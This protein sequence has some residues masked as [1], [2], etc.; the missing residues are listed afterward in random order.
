MANAHDSAETAFDDHSFDA[1]AL[2][3]AGSWG[4]G[5]A[6]A[7]FLAVM[8]GMSDTG[9]PRVMAALS[10]VTG[11]ADTPAVKTVAAA[12]PAP[13][14]VTPA[15]APQPAAETRRL[16]EQVQLL[17]ADRDRLAQRIGTLERNLE[18]V[19]GSIRQQE[20]SAKAASTTPPPTI[21]AAMSM[22]AAPWPMPSQEQS[23]PTSP[24]NDPPQETTPPEVTASLPPATPLPPP[25][26]ELSPAEET[27]PAA[28]A[29]A[30][31]PKSQP[32][33]SHPPRP[34]R[35]T[36]GIDL[37]G[38]VSVDRLRMLWHSLRSGDPRL[39]HGLRPVVQIR[40]IRRGGRPDIRLIVGPLA[41]ADDASKLCS[42]ILNSGRYCEPAL[43]RGRRLQ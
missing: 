30:A 10:A 40:D 25:R 24:W 12:K 38:A 28:E 29:E 41:S 16:I 18:D 19:T 8:A 20:A 7:L 27:A 39:L 4:I 17:A 32:V 37:G 3:R 13:R 15:R 22:S 34:A 35:I 6:A 43:Y 23:G 11:K 33:T 36:Y 9:A 1:S 2:V 14:P 31:E 21:P 42:A 5:A 26:P